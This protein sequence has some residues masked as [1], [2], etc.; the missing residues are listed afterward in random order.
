MNMTMIDI[1]YLVGVSKCETTQSTTKTWRMG[2]VGGTGREGG[3]A[4][5]HPAS[6]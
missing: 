3:W 1:M 4:P 2:R 5:M 6:A